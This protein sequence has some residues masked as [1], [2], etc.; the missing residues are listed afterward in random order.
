MPR[1]MRDGRITPSLPGVEWLE[2]RRLLSAVLEATRTLVIEGT[3]AADTITVDLQIGR[4]GARDYRVMVNGEVDEFR[5]G[6]VRR[7]LIFAHGGDDTVRVG[8]GGFVGEIHISAE[9]HGGDGNDS[10]TGDRGNDVFFGGDG[11]DFIVGFRG[12]D[13]VSGGNG[14]DTIVVHIGRDTVFGDA[15]NDLID[16]QETGRASILNGGEGDDQIVGTSRRDVLTGGPGN[17]TLNGGRGNN[18]LFGEGGNDTITVN[19]NS[20]RILGGVGA[21]TFLGITNRTRG[22]VR[23]F[24]PGLDTLLPPAPPTPEPPPDVT[25]GILQDGEQDLLA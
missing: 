17:D 6:D 12:N 18:R 1:R 20:E 23:D 14:N 16:G 24:E 10:I 7:F 2:T 5:A 13:R 11:D 9:V 21:D 25:S 19:S 15:G 8:I 22:A 4:F 3:D